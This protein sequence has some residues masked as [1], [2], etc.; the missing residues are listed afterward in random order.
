MKK[1]IFPAII[2]WVVVTGFIYA[3]VTKSDLLMTW[4]YRQVARDL[5]FYGELWF[6][7]TSEYSYYYPG[8]ST[9][10]LGWASR[11]TLAHEI[12][13]H[14]FYCMVYG[15][16]NQQ[17]LDLFTRLRTLPLG[18]IS[19]YADTYPCYDNS[20]CLRAYN[21]SLAEVAD[22]A[23]M[24]LLKAV[25]QEWQDIYLDI[26]EWYAGQLATCQ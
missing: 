4:Y 14:K 16:T 10:V 25:P 17:A 7:H 2:A 20:S 23:H 3:L 21:E 8:K 11:D 1:F 18:G 22:L 15:P 19:Y 9:I 5:G 6:D 24:G 26:N 12:E 13:H